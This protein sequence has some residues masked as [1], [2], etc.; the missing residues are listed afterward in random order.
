MRIRRIHILA[1]VVFVAVCCTPAGGPTRHDP[2]AACGLDGSGTGSAAAA[3]DALVRGRRD[4]A[5]A[6]GRGG[7]AWGDVRLRTRLCGPRAPDAGRRSGGREP[8]D[9]AHPPG[10]LYGL[11][12]VPVAD[13]VGRRPARRGSRCRRAGQQPLLRRRRRRHPH[14]DRRI[15]PLRNTP[16]GRVCGQR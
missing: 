4:A 7:T 12:A 6:A 8:R 1:A 13:G 15:G 9:H 11:S 2:A 5:P 3:D 16:H 10:T 14:D